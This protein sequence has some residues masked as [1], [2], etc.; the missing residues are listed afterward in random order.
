MAKKIHFLI[1]DPQNDFCDQERGQL[2]VKG[3]DDDMRRLA[4]LINRIHSA[5]TEVHVTLDSHHVV[6]VAH[7]IYWKDRDGKHPSKFTVIRAS[8]VES[9]HWTPSQ[10][11]WLRSSRDGFGALDYV[12][13]LEAN[14]KYPL[15]IWPPH[16]LVG[17]WGHNVFPPLLDALHQWE[18][19]QFKIV[20]FVIKGS[21]CHTEHYSALSADVPDPTDPVTHVNHE[22]LRWLRDADEIVIAGEAASHCL[23]NT[24]IDADTHCT[25][26]SFARKLILLS[27]AT[28]CIQGHHDQYDDFVRDFTG[29][30]MRVMT[31]SEYERH[32]VDGGR[33]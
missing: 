12:S 5:I 10:Q 11:A 20:R 29:R 24:A 2:A 30:G 19:H 33:G 26:G 7:P 31:T 3:A 22:L 16:C 32:L 25:D 18:A 17:S 9:G 28:S 21:N 1:I 6:H 27:D 14:G 23:A 4:S 13:A 15:C 8:D